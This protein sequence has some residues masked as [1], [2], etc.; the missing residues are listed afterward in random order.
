[1]SSESDWDYVQYNV[2]VGPRPRKL[3]IV[4]GATHLIEEPGTLEKVEA[5]AARWFFDHHL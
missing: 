5:H 2:P 3:M 4:P 1:M